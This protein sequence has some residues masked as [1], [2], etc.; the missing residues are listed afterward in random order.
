MTYAACKPICDIISI[1]SLVVSDE[2]IDFN[3]F[4]SEESSQYRETVNNT[5]KEHL[6]FS[7]F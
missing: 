1:E 7:F 4:A 2:T 5:P 3:S 6:S